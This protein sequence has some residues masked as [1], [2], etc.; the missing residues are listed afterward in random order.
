MQKKCLLID[1]DSTIPNLALMKISTWKKQQG[2]EVGFNIDDP[3]EIY[4]SIVF[5]KNKHKT[6][7]LECFYPNALINRGGT[8]WD[9]HSKLP[10]EVDLLP[11][12]IRSIQIVIMI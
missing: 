7:G 6:D 4:A 2:Y 12:I 11:Q 10:D 8:G 9:I 3:D 1:V 5:E